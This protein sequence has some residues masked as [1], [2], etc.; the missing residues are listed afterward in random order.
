MDG[1]AVI[2]VH[3]VKLINAAD[4]LVSQHQGAAFQDLCTQ[5]SH[6]RENSALGQT[7]THMCQ[8]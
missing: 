3:L 6:L 5:Q 2:L 4:A 8:A 7:A 1:C